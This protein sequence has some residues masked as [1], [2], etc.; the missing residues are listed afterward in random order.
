VPSALRLFYGK[1]AA[2]PVGNL[3]FDKAGNLYGV[4]ESC[5]SGFSCEGVVFEIT[6]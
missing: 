1:P 3:I 5:G 6:P 2:S 4:T